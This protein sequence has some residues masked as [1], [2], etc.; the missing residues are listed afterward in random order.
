[1]TLQLL[2]ITDDC[3]IMLQIETDYCIAL[4][5]QAHPGHG[6]VIF[7]SWNSILSPDEELCMD[8]LRSG[9]GQ[10]KLWLHGG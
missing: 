6:M 5:T 3:I 10:V 2:S 4:G 7:R 8:R 9:S 1:M